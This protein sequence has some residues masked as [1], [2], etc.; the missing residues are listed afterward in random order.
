MPSLALAQ[1]FYQDATRAPELEA[2]NDVAHPL[3]MPATGIR[4]AA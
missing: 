2:M 1:L 4:L 3:F